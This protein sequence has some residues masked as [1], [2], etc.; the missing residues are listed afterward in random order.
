MLS[1]KTNI[2]AAHLDPQGMACVVCWK[3]SVSQEA[4]STALAG[5]KR[6]LSRLLSRWHS[7]FPDSDIDDEVDTTSVALVLVRTRNH[8]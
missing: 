8:K 4:V 1:N 5:A 6:G 7:S 2:G 3:C